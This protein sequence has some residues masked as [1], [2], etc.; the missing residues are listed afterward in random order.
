M[1]G[2]LIEIFVN[3]LFSIFLV[4]S[5]DLMAGTLAAIFLLEANLKMKAAHYE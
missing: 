1:L 2:N 3:P 5:L 4:S